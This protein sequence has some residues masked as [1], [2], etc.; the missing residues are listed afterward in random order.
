MSKSVPGGF[1]RHDSKRVQLEFN[2]P[3]LTLQSF[4]AQ[5][6]IR[7]IMAQYKRTGIVTH[8][9]NARE[10]IGDFTDIPDYQESLNKVILAEEAFN[11]LPAKMRERFNNDPAKLIAFC[12]DESNRDEAIILGLIDRVAEQPNT[13]KTSSEDDAA[14]RST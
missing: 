5:C 4:S 13:S 7:N 1:R 11:A 14:P 3:S 8:I 6:D 9:S 2:D 12:M 10:L